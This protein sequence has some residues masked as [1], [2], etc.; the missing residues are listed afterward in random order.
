MI[1][2]ILEYFYTKV[3]KLFYLLLFVFCAIMQALYLKLNLFYA[4]SL[5]FLPSL[6]RSP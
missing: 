1:S 2:T 6:I 5:D 4:S 3:K